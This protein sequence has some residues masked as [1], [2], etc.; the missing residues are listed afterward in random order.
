MQPSERGVLV[1]H[2]PSKL[3][4]YWNFAAWCYYRSLLG[5]SYRLVFV[6]SLFAHV[7]LVSLAT[8]EITIQ[9]SVLFRV[10]AEYKK[11]FGL[12]I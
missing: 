6:L 5:L 9:L 12:P 10:S 3:K 4:T 7:F 8:L 11:Y 1:T 2:P